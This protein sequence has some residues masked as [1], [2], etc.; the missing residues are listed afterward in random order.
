MCIQQTIVVPEQEAQKRVGG[1]VQKLVR[2]GYIGK[3]RPFTPSAYFHIYI[4]VGNFRA[5]VAP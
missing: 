4:G 3:K 1:G 5:G 2:G